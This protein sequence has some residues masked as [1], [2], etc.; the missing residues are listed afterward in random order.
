MLKISDSLAVFFQLF[1]PPYAMLVNRGWKE[2][3]QDHVPGKQDHV[4]FFQVISQWIS[5]HDSL[6]IHIE[7][8]HRQ[9][10]LQIVDC[11]NNQY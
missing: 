11:N 5:Q 4:H 8:H 10:F 1:F 6:E 2:D 7:I 9:C 3:Q